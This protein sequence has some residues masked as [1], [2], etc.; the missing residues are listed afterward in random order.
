VKGKWYGK[1]AAT[2]K[3]AENLRGYTG[4]GLALLTGRTHAY[5]YRY[6]EAFLSQVAS[7]DGAERF[8]N[9]LG[10]WATYLW[11][12]IET[13]AEAEHPHHLQRWPNDGRTWSSG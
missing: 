1:G 11:H 12:P 10:S 6:T 9:T 4:D 13:A 2:R 5:G 7:A 3:K 8:T